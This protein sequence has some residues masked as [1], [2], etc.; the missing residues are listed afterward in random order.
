M[1][2]VKNR[3]F[4][5][6]HNFSSDDVLTNDYKSDKFESYS[7]KG[8]TP[9]NGK[10][11]YKAK[12]NLTRD[13]NRNLSA[14]TDTEG[15]IIFPFGNQYHFGFFQANKGGK[16][17]VTFQLDG[18]NVEFKGRKFNWFVK[19]CTNNE[20]QR[21]NLRLGAN[22]W[23]S[24]C[25]SNTRVQTEEVDG[26]RVFALS[27][28]TMCRH[29]NFLYG[30][31]GTLNNKFE[32]ITYDGALGY[33]TKDF[34]LYLRHESYVDRK[35]N[36]PHTIAHISG[37]NFSLGKLIASAVYRK[38]NDTFCGEVTHNDGN[39]GKVG[40]T[41]GV[42]HKVNSD[43]TAK[44]KADNNLNVFIS[45]K[46]KYSRLLTVTGTVQLDLKNLKEG[47]TNTNTLLPVPLGLEFGLNL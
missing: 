21:L 35:N 4:K 24:K 22:Y 19:A 34:D 25:E 18:G 36:N 28:R 33:E 45:L 17:T 16:S 1:Q 32:A 42:N 30:F 26:N 29:N 15:K 6:L 31:A 12:V 3:S 38:G 46:N 20:F 7:V 41:V 43:L 9:N 5:F 27:Q 11:E 10:F 37:G 13:E 14:K 47:K 8:T 23:G 44:A 2:S 40:F 39:N